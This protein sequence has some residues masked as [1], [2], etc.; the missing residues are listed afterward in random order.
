LRL[1]EWL[2]ETAIEIR[3]TVAE[4]LSPGIPIVEIPPLTAFYLEF[5]Q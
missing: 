1:I 3:L 2:T 4:A 5:R